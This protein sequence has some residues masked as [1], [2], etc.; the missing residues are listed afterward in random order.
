MPEGRFRYGGVEAALAE[1][2]QIEPESMGAFRARLR[3]LRNLGVPDLPKIG[4][5]SVAA[6]SREQALEMLLALELENVGKAP[7]VAAMAA[8]SILRTSD[9]SSASR[10]NVLIAFDRSSSAAYTVLTGRKVFL[11]W[12]K[13]APRAF[14]II[15]L[16]ACVTVLD[17][18]LA[19]EVGGRSV[20]R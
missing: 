6:Y 5:G 9:H 16:T 17:A 15:D 13:S 19:K 11:R 18:A 12:L 20:V 3:H 7:R 1:A 4:S 2:L 8:T 14:A 10:E